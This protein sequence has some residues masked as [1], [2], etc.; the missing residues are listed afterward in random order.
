MSIHYQKYSPTGNVTLLVT[1]PV[2]RKDQP[3]IAARLLGPGGVGVE[4]AGFIEPAGDARCPARLQMMGGEF[5]GNA[6]MALGA[7][8]CR[9]EALADGELRSLRLEVSGASGTVPCA[10]LRAISDSTDENHSM[11]FAT[12]M[13]LAVENSHKIL[14]EVLK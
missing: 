4:Q 3:G 13:P 5:C 10:I 1:T 2:P 14:M 8:L 11:E 6:T 9:R 7:L 12:F